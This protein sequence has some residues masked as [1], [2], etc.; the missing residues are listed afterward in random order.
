MKSMIFDGLSMG[1]EF[2][3]AATRMAAR[4]LQCWLELGDLALRN[5]LAESATTLA[6]AELAIDQDG[7]TWLSRAHVH[8]VLTLLRENATIYPSRFRELGRVVDEAFSESAV[9][10]RRRVGVSAA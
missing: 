8:G 7:Q 2:D 3:G 6:A 9:V 5:L 10:W 4:S 1:L